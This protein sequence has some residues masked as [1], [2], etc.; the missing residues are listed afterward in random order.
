MKVMKG[1]GMMGTAIGPRYRVARG[2]AMASGRRTRHV[3]RR[4][5]GVNGND[6]NGDRQPAQMSAEM[7]NRLREAE[8]EA[9]ELR[10]QL[11][12]LKSNEEEGLHRG[13]QGAGGGGRGGR[14][15]G[16][17]EREASQ[18]AGGQGGLRVHQGKLFVPTKRR[19]A[20]R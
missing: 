7:L 2:P 12:D 1:A 20:G 5:G 17:H 13:R 6:E 4:A 16:E 14:D 15:E 8:A 11:A 10:K 3:S 19:V 18:P 9:A